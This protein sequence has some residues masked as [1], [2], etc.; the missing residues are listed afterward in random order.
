MSCAEVLYRFGSSERQVT[1]LSTWSYMSIKCCCSRPTSA[2]KSSVTPSKTLSSFVSSSVTVCLTHSATCAATR[3]IS[4]GGEPSY[5]TTYLEIRLQVSFV[6]SARRL[7]SPVVLYPRR[8]NAQQAVSE[9]FTSKLESVI[10]RTSGPR[11]EVAAE[12]VGASS[13]SPGVYVPMPAS[14]CQW[15]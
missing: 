15:C 8:P 3:G 4:A 7:R 6:L 10:H 11:S 13:L 5:D 14:G 9:N 1:C 12:P 2:A